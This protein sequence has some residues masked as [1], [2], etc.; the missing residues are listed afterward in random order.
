MYC[1]HLEASGSRFARGYIGMIV[2]FKF[3]HHSNDRLDDEGNDIWPN[4][5][6]VYTFSC[7]S[8]KHTGE[9]AFA[10][11]VLAV[12]VDEVAAVNIEG[13][14]RQVHEDV[15][16]ILLAWFLQNRSMSDLDW[17]HVKNKDVS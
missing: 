1:S 2:H 10:A 8:V 4:L 5:L 11:C 13:V 6:N 7:Q 12:W 17:L 15:T 9:S 16:Q 14:I 3:R